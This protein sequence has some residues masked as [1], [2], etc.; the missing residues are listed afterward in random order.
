MLASHAWLSALCPVGDDVRR[1]AEAL[2]SRGLTVD[3]VAPAGE[4]HALDVDVPA[5]RPDCLGHLGLARELSAALGVPLREPQGPPAGE[6]GPVSDA[7][8]V[9]IE[10]PELCTRYAA[11]LVRSVRVGPSPPW[12]A[13][14]LE[15]CGLRS[16]NNVVDVSNL[17]MLELGHPVHFFDLDAVENGAIRIRRARPGE[18]LTTLDGVERA[19]DEEILVIADATDPIALAGVMGGAGSEIGPATRNVLIEAAWFD[20]SIVRAA[21]RKL[22][23]HTDASHRFGRGVDPAGV[24]AAQALAMRLLAELGGGVPAPGII[25]EYPA[26][27]AAPELTLRPGQLR[28]LLGYQPSEDE[29]QEA[30]SALELSPTPLEGGR[31][32]TTVP[33]WRVDLEREADLVEEVARHLGYDRVPDEATG[34]PVTATAAERGNVEERTRDLLAH[35]GFHEALGYAMTAAGE[36]DPFVPEGHPPGIRLTNPIAESLA[37]LRRSV[38][39]GLVRAA[40]LNHRRGVRDVRL[41]EVGHAFVGTSRGEFPREPLRAAWVWSGAARPLH[42]AG[43]ARDVDLYDVMGVVERLLERLGAPPLTRRRGAVPALHPGRSATWRTEDGSVVAWCGALHPD[44]QRSLPHELFVAEV[45]IGPPLPA[46]PPIP[47]Y[48]PLPR[49]TAVARDISLVLTPGVDYDRVRE[50]LESVDPPAPVTIQAVDRYE[51]PSLGPGEASLT[52]RILLQPAEKT[53]TE[54]EIDGYRRALIDSL[55]QGL[56]LRIRE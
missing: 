38:L 24:P 42:W 1:V 4:D 30:L 29:I 46:S 2:T 32:R 14:R 43:E 6:G 28:R 33:S 49:L 45:E 55:R 5:N 21:S 54:Q 19:L 16:V 35:Q 48:S 47:Q 8:S 56:G 10:D 39:P 7:A 31:V 25:D 13:R 22:A 52:V 11:G 44:L 9:R 37:L 36:D 53:L 3:S 20:P 51:G 18:R 41:F 50:T 17:V 34:I 40:E 26:P 15:V 12:V 27:A 23:L